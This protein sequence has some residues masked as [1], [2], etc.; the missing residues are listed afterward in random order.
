MYYIYCYTNKINN[1]KYVGQT[2]NFKRRVREHRYEATHEV[3]PSYNHLFHQK[4]REYGEENFTIEVIEVLYT[5]NI[6]EVNKREIYWIS[7]MNSFCQDGQGYNMDIGGSRKERTSILSKDQLKELKNEIKEGKSYLGLQEKYNISASFISSI[8]NGIYFKDD[9][10][11]YPLYKYYK[12][13][14]DYEEL[15]ELL[16][17]STFSLAEIARMLDMGYSTVKKI[18]AGTLRNGLYPTYP[19]RTKSANEQRADKIKELLLTTSL[20]NREIGEMIGASEE[21]V[22][23]VK[24]GQVFRD[25]KLSYPLSNL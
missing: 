7:Q 14:E 10:E 4:L 8:N 15:I 5:D 12:D 24:I 3:A 22:R 2:N 1:H 18:N 23:R 13:D 17:H 20:S 25:E 16:L 6:D 19:I 21:T 11:N 9:N